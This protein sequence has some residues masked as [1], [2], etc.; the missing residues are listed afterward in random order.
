MLI[1]GPYIR[2]SRRRRRG[3]RKRIKEGTIL[4]NIRRNWLRDLEETCTSA[5]IEME[6]VDFFLILLCV[7]I[8]TGNFEAGVIFETSEATIIAHTLM[9]RTESLV[10]PHLNYTLT[11]EV[12]SQNEGVIENRDKFCQ[13]SDYF[14]PLRVFTVRDLIR[15]DFGCHWP[16]Y[17]DCVLGHTP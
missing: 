1:V 10:D 15:P 16:S 9:R 13:Q 7:I 14:R 2:E 5:E 8:S 12:V 3:R 4:Q 6:T 17:N 11:K